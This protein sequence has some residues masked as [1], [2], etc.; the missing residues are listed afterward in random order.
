MLPS[1]HPEGMD[2]FLFWDPDTAVSH[3]TSTSWGVGFGCLFQHGRE[4]FD[5]GQR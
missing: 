4:T 5:G 3:I 2:T 1:S